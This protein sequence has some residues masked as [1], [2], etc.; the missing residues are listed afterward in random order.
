VAVKNQLAEERSRKRERLNQLE[1]EVSQLRDELE[2]DAQLARRSQEGW[3]SR[4]AD[5]L[6]A[7]TAERRTS[8]A[9]ASAA[10]QLAGHNWDLAITA[11]TGRLAHDFN[12]Y[13]SVIKGCIDQL[14][15]QLPEQHPTQQ[16]L[17]ALKEA[18]QGCAN[19]TQQLLM[20]APKRTVHS[21]ICD[22]S[23]PT[24][25]LESSAKNAESSEADLPQATAGAHRILLVDDDACVRDLLVKQ[26]D[27]AG[28]QVHVA[29]HGLSALQRLTEAH[30]DLVLSDTIMPKLGGIQLAREI[31]Q[32]YP[33]VR[34]MLMTGHSI[35]AVHDDQQDTGYP[36]LRKPF[37][38]EE[39]LHAVS[40]ALS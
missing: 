29:E 39:L 31:R 35:E 5:A 34:V 11:L 8:D 26:L 36:I 32:H 12:N 16:P 1:A 15:E 23:T 37:S 18:C 24:Q 40:N 6:D 7:Y 17:A 38:Y 27:Y 30:Y 10:P 2:L 28:Y 14:A 33:R 19:L 13:L 9:E 4:I 20:L 25:R 3:T 22:L 21:D